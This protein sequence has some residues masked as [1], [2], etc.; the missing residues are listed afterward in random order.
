MPGVVDFVTAE[1]I[2]G[3]NS[4]AFAAPG[5]EELL[6]A[7]G[8]D[9]KQAGTS[10]VG[11]PIGVIVAKSRREAEAA[12]RKAA[13]ALARVARR[14]RAEDERESARERREAAFERL[15]A[16]LREANRAAE[17]ARRDAAKA[18]AEAARKTANAEAD[19]VFLAALHGR[20]DNLRRWL[21]RF[22]E[23]DLTR[24]QLYSMTAMQFA[25]RYG[26]ARFALETTTGPSR[27]A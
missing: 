6:V 8:D 10:Y 19:A 20:H 2:P 23:W 9:G 26:G 27:A 15:E 25:T 5:H 22:P 11:Q 24:R 14:E 18:A 12:S 1:D 4:V 3:N 16:D 17:E 21:G 7:A 13:E